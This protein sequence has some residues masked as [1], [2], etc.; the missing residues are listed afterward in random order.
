MEGNLLTLPAFTSIFKANVRICL[1]MSEYDPSMFEYVGI[2]PNIPVGT[3]DKLNFS[4]GHP[5]HTFDNT[6][7]RVAKILIGVALVQ[8]NDFRPSRIRFGAYSA[9]MRSIFGGRRGCW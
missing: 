3:I 6:H 9:L 7:F 8:C 4:I 1:N 5:K 2:C